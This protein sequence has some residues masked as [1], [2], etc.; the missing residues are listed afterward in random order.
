MLVQK[1][2]YEFRRPRRW[3]VAVF[4]F[5]GEPT[6][7]YVKRVVGLP[8]ESIRIV[9]GDIYVDGRIVR[10]SLAEIRAMRILIHDSRFQPA[11]AGAIS[12]L[13]VSGR[14]RDYRSR[15]TAVGRSRTAGSST[16]PSQGDARPTDDWLVYKHWDPSTGRYGPVRD[17]YAYN[18]GDVR[19]DNEVKDLGMEARL[20]VERS[21]RVDLGA[22]SVR[23][24]SVRGDGFRSR[25]RGS[26]ELRAKRSANS[27]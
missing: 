24:R 13:A 12:S 10:K 3:E 11:D 16:A 26:I 27:V 22:D 8:G 6:Q 20:S 18:G 25:S 7:A 14:Q 5:P 17:F 1:F 4:H 15:A 2:L 23:L 9:G 21:G 19:A